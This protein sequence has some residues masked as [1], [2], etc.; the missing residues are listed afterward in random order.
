[1]NKETGLPAQV[2]YQQ[3]P[4]MDDEIDVSELF[5]KIWLRRNFIIAF[6][7]IAGVLALGIS[8]VGLLKKF[9]LATS[10]RLKYYQMFIIRII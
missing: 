3:Y 6:V 5:N 4:E 7:F 1:M 9:L 8:S 2:V 10:F